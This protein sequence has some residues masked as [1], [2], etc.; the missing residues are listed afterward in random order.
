VLVLT[1]GIDSLGMVLND[2]HTRGLIPADEYGIVI[3]W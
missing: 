2:L 1:R 3:D